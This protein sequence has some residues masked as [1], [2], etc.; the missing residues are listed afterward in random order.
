MY[1]FMMVFMYVFL[2]AACTVHMRVVLYVTEAHVLHMCMLYSASLLVVVD[3]M[4]AFY[5]LFEVLLIAMYLYLQQY[6]VLARAVYALYM[7]CIYT[8]LGSALLG[9]GLCIQY[10]ITGCS[11]AM[12]AVG[13]SST[14]HG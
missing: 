6:C 4:L 7:L 13:Y 10:S 8:I 14:A 5:A 1:V 11:A 9:I 2:M 3:D 12:Y